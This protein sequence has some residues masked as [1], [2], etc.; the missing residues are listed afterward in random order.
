MK[1]LKYYE[2]STPSRII[3]AILKEFSKQVVVVIMSD[4]INSA[5]VLLWKSFRSARSGFAMKVCSVS[6]LTCCFFSLF[7]DG[8][9]H[10]PCCV[11]E[12][13]PD[14]C[15][16]LCR[17]EYTTVTDNVK[18][19]FSCPSYIE[20]T[21]SCIA[22][23]VGKK[24]KFVSPQHTVCLLLLFLNQD[25]RKLFYAAV[26][27]PSQLKENTRSSH[28]CKTHF[29][30]QTHWQS[31]ANGFTPNRKQ[32]KPVI[33]SLINSSENFPRQILK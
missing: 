32:E 10:V 14:I 8:R 1:S 21:L 16:D 20:R 22:D 26:F 15:Q 2:S 33:L 23:G 28:T 17:G 31:R 6:A 5:E 30:T 3:I 12:G 29:I 19:H 24:S 13:V 9:D 18:T 25:L 4:E 11:R 27:P 7:A